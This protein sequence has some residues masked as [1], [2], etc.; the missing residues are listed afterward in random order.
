MNGTAND[1]VMTNYENRTIEPLV[2]AAVDE[3]K[4]KFLTEE[5]RANGESVLYFRD[6]FKLAPVSMVAEMADKFT[7]NEIMTSNEF[8]QIIGM[9]PSKDPNADRLRNANI[10]QSK[11]DIAAAGQAAVEKNLS[12]AS[13]Q[14]PY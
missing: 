9:K 12:G 14:L 6:P 4:R 5:A 7:R 1:T 10:S 11:E 8:R 3:L 2:A 13:R